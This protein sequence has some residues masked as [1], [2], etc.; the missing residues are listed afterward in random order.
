MANE[1]KTL[2]E[3]REGE[4]IKIVDAE[5]LN[6]IPRLRNRTLICSVIKFNGRLTYF[7]YFSPETGSGTLR[8]PNNPKVEVLGKEDFVSLSRFMQDNR[9]K[10]VRPTR[11]ELNING[12]IE[13][14]DVEIGFWHQNPKNIKLKGLSRFGTQYSVPG[15]SIV[16]QIIKK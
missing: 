6:K 5:L 11:I 12:H 15:S 3:V 10:E 14:F 9:F 7:Q 8:T 4:K 13:E 16:K 1:I 2:S